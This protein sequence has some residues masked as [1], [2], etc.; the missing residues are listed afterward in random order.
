MILMNS[1][2]TILEHV[3]ATGTWEEFCRF[4]GCLFLG[5]KKLVWTGPSVYGMFVLSVVGSV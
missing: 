3:L 1:H 4:L 2:E 5:G